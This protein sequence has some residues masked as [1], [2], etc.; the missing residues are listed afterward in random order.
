MYLNP[1]LQFL[2]A[3]FILDEAYPPQRLLTFILIWIAMG[4]FL[5]GMWQTHR[6]SRRVAT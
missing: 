4:F 5:A 1:T 3:V 6:R 2:S